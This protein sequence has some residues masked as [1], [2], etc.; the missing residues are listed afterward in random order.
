M[1][2]RSFFKFLPIAPVALVAEGTKLAASEYAPHDGNLSITIQSSLKKN[3][4]NNNG[5]SISFNQ[6]DPGKSASLSVGADGNL[7]LKNSSDN[8][9]RKIM[10]E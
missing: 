5:S 4:K 6:V 10:V 7:W 1:D 9:W 8:S 2:R 3:P